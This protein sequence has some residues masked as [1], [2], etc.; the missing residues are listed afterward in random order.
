MCI[1]RCQQHRTLQACAAW[2]PVLPLATGRAA[3]AR[4]S[5]RLVLLPHTLFIVARCVLTLTSGSSLEE[6]RGM[7]TCA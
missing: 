2:R 3:T 6:G 5:A 7:K 4:G 1:E